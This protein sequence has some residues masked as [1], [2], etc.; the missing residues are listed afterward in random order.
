MLFRSTPNFLY[1]DFKI[2][3]KFKLSKNLFRRVRARD[4]FNAVFAS[5]RQYTIKPGETPDSIANACI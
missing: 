5:S 4:S 1:P 3:G 2:S